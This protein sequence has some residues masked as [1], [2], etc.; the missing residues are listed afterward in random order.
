VGALNGAGATVQ[1]LGNASP[2]AAPHGCYPCRA[3]AAG[4]SDDDAWCVIAV[5]TD[6]QWAGL[7]RAMGEPAWAAAPALATAAGRLACAADLDERVAVWTRQHTPRAVM[8]RCQ[9]HGVPAGIVATG[10]DLARDPHLAARGFLM[11][12]EHPRMGKLPMPGCPVRFARHPTAVWRYGP[13]LGEDG[14]H[15]WRG[16]VGM[17]PDE[18]LPLAERGV[19]S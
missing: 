18:L 6:A 9:A 3:E 5:E 7:Q 12:L 17:T 8:E 13:L 15:V 2:I 19:L 4:W 16:T 14:D 10:E 11:D 1:P